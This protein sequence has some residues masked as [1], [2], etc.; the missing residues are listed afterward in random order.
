VTLLL[1]SVR[2]PEEARI[3]LDAGVDLIDLKEPGAGALGAVAPAVARAVVGLVAGRVPVSA[4]VGD[5]GGRDPRLPAI[6]TALVEAGVDI[7]KVG[8]FDAHAVE[9][10]ESL[11]RRHPGLALVPV[12]FAEDPWRAL[13]L[14]RFAAAGVR[15]LMIDTRLKRAGSL[16]TR[17][18][19]DELSALRAASDS[20]GLQLGLAGG[21]ALDDLPSVLGLGPAVVGLRGALCEGRRTGRLSSA[22]VVAARAAVP[23]QAPA[24][25][26]RRWRHDFVA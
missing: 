16:L 10:L 20:A 23:R 6:A 21:L 11:A 1:A 22:C 26:Q 5:L 12:A 19:R 17:L 4:T 3:C 13:P 7:L 14:A 2:S 9:A 24:D 8:C 18:A 15:L 25:G